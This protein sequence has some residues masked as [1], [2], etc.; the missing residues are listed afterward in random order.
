MREPPGLCIGKMQLTH[1]AESLGILGEPLLCEG[2]PEI[3]A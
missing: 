2:K 1:G 3:T